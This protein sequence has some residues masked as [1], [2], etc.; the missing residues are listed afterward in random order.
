[1]KR[2]PHRHTMPAVHSEGSVPRA[3]DAAPLTSEQVTAGLRSERLA[4]ARLV[5]SGTMSGL[6][7]AVMIPLPTAAGLVPCPEGLLPTTRFPAVSCS[8]CQQPIPPGTPC[9]VTRRSISCDPP[10]DDGIAEIVNR[11]RRRQAPPASGGEG[12]GD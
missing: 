12:Q 9:Y 10:C 6:D 4:V 2:Y 7:L 8:W 11:H 5:W 1:V 3:A